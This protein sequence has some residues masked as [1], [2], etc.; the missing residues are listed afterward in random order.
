MKKILLGLLLISLFLPSVLGITIDYSTDNATWQPITFMNQTSQTGYQINLQPQTKYYFRA[1]DGLSPYQY[2]SQTTK[3]N[4][5]KVSLAITIFIL[6][7][8]GFLIYLAMNKTFSKNQFLDL[9]LRRCLWIIVIYLMTFNSAIM[10]TIAAASGF[11][12][13]QEMF[14]YMWLFGN[15]GWVFMGFVFFMTLI[16][17]FRLW[18][19]KKES[20]RMGD[21]ENR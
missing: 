11:N 14:T 5:E 18:K 13:Q 1:Q 17:I 12:L 21:D 7:V 3:E 10:G 2:F 16:Q 15:A 20:D 9:I 6:S 19:I 4:G 8:T